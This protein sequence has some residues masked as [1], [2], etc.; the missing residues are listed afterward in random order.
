MN[1]I[2]LPDIA[3]PEHR[4]LMTQLQ[5]LREGPVDCFCWNVSADARWYAIDTLVRSRCVLLT[6]DVFINNDGERLTARLKTTGDWIDPL[7]RLASG[8]A[9][10]HYHSA[11]ASLMLQEMFGVGDESPT[12]DARSEELHVRLGQVFL[13]KRFI[14]SSW[15]NNLRQA[16]F[17]AVS[18]RAEL[19]DHGRRLLQTIEFEWP[20][21]ETLINLSARQDTLHLLHESTEAWRDGVSINA[22]DEPE[23]T[24]DGE[25]ASSVSV[26][27]DIVELLNAIK[28][29]VDRT[30]SKVDILSGESA[31][32]YGISLL[33]AALLITEGDRTAAE[34]TKKR[35]HRSSK[36]E[37]IGRAE[38]KSDTVLYSPTVLAEFIIEQG[39]WHDGAKTLV[40]L[41]ESK[42]EPAGRSPHT[43]P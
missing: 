35:W 18:R 34:K 29:G 37:G 36:P 8:F 26:D 42:V 12:V 20:D 24:I 40:A 25:V 11:D 38:K 10:S 30:E 3:N 41:L 4:Q 43:V 6:T 16:K 13:L 23:P 22:G 39:D 2:I 32:V 27:V 9:L 1:Q 19:T 15:V 21:Q 28:D 31:L 7:E 14:P 33:S 5:A 17:C